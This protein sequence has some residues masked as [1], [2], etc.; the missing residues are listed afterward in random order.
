M[1]LVNINNHFSVLKDQAKVTRFLEHISDNSEFF[2][3]NYYNDYVT[4]KVYGL[5]SRLEN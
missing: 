4:E 3:T 2:K 5:A 1:I